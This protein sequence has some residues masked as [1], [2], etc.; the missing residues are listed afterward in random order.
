M[1]Q[2][3]AGMAVLLFVSAL[4]LVPMLGWGAVAAIVLAIIGAACIIAQL[5]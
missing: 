3:P 1:K 5:Q 2:F 4:G